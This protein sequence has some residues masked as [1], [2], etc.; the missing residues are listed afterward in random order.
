MP[1]HSLTHVV[2][3]SCSISLEHLLASMS[4]LILSTMHLN[5]NRTRHGSVDHITLSCLLAQLISL[6]CYHCHSNIVRN[7]LV[8][9]YIPS[10]RYQLCLFIRNVAYLKFIILNTDKTLP[11]AVK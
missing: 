8:E 5:A 9:G 1:V 3:N 2:T 11:T 4:P 10:V 7:I 6:T